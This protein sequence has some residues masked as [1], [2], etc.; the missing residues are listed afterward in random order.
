MGGWRLVFTVKRSST[1]GDEPQEISR[2]H[3]EWKKVDGRE[4]GPALKR[5]EDVPASSEGRR[6]GEGKS[7]KTRLGRDA[8][9]REGGVS[10]S[11]QKKQNQ[12]ERKIEGK[13]ANVI[14]MKKGQS[15]GARG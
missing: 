7:S 9:G 10:P 12:Q 13:L 8:A 5:I 14:L 2:H 15:E 4:E 1:S 6:R 11:F 3:Q